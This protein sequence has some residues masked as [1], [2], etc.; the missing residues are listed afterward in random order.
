[1]NEANVWVAYRKKYKV[2]TDSSHNK[3][4]FENL[5]MRYFDVN[6]PDQVYVGDIIY[7]WTREGWL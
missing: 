3:P 5:V 7:M 1:M 4:L 2:T 6:A